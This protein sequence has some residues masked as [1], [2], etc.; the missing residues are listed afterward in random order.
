M[1]LQLN[2]NNAGYDSSDK[3]V[4][5]SDLSYYDRKVMQQKHSAIIILIRN[6][7]MV[8]NERNEI[9]YCTSPTIQWLEKNERENKMFSEMEF[10]KNF[11]EK[12]EISDFEPGV[13]SIADEYLG[14]S[15]E[16]NDSICFSWIYEIYQEKQEDMPFIEKLL[17]VLCHVPSDK[18]TDECVKIVS[19][20]INQKSDGIKEMAVRAFENW[21]YTDAIPFLEKT[22]FDDPFLEDY[23][24]GVIQDLKELKNGLDGQKN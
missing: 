19:E 17:G 3:L 16:N 7:F 14:M 5:L 12:V 15:I 6:N 11:S 24:K 13:F 20:A 22:Y 4:Y 10:K 9:D 2:N 23:L 1:I 18:I 21:E 8:I